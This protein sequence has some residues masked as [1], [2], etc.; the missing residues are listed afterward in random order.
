MPTQQLYSVYQNT[1]DKELLTETY[2]VKS[3]RRCRDN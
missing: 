1:S 2:Q 3:V